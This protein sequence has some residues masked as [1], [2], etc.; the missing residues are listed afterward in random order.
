MQYS[1]ASVD[2]LIRD[3]AD[4][5]IDVKLQ[6]IVTCARTAEFAERLS[7]GKPACSTLVE[8]VVVVAA[9]AADT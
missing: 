7:P 6:A 2:D 9:S 1:D 5:H 4:V 8:V 3:M